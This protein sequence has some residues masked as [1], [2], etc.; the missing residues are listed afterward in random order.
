VAAGVATRSVFRE[1]E[2]LRTLAVA[3]MAAVVLPGCE[4]DATSPNEAAG[5]F[6]VQVVDEQFRVRIDD[7]PTAAQARALISN[8]RSINVNGEIERGN[9]GFNAGYSW[10]LDPTTV[11]FVDVTI[12]LCDGM[13]SYV[14]ANVDYYVDTVKQ[15][16]PWGAK[17]VSEVNTQ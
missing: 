15:Y 8:G 11:E 10:H 6:V 7:G 4:E 17:V 1:D 9:G 16:C 12:E 14:E 2:V 13:P 3:V 5:T